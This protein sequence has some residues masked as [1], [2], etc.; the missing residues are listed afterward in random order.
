MVSADEVCAGLGERAENR[1]C[2]WDLLA[3][4]TG[5]RETEG[6]RI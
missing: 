6:I 4:R 2:P 1:V 3:D 5:T